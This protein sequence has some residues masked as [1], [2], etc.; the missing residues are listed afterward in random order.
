MIF[1]SANIVFSNFTTFEFVD[2]RSSALFAQGHLKGA[3]SI[4]ISLNVAAWKKYLRSWKKESIDPLQFLPEFDRDAFTSLRSSSK[5]VVLYTVA[6]DP[7]NFIL[8]RL[9]RQEQWPFYILEGG[10][11]AFLREQDHFLASPRPYYL[12]CGLT[13]VGKTK[14]LRALT[15]LGEQVLDLEQIAL[16]RGSVFGQEGPGLSPFDLQQQV[17]LQLQNIP[18]QQRIFLEQKGAF[19]GT[20][21]LPSTL[22]EQMKGAKKIMLQAPRA[23]RIQHLLDSYRNLDAMKAQ[24]QLAKLK[25]RLSPSH[26]QAA[27]QAIEQK[28]RAAFADHLLRYYDQTKQY[29]WPDKA[30]DWIVDIK[31]M[32]IEA[33]AK[34]I[35]EIIEVA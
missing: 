14:T 19:L 18:L 10:Y 17:G 31:G 30:I 22:I 13:G 5:T 33:V 29:A 26:Y 2:I 20:T 11:E 27:L 15:Q 23:Q 25:A 28:D 7:L 35:L 32:S 6:D 9:L 4:P 1:L 21:P 3:L 24:R 16:H 34:R 12:L 8:P